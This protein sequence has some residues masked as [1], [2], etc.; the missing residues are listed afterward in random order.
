MSIDQSLI[1]AKKYEA[2]PTPLK[3]AV[4]GASPQGLDI[5]PYTALRALQHIGQA[6]Q[7]QM[8]QQAQQAPAAQ[9][10]P[11]IADAELAKAFGTGGIVAFAHG[12]TPIQHFDEGDEV[13]S[14]EEADAKVASQD[15][16]EL[17]GDPNVMNPYIERVKGI[18]PHVVDKNADDS[19]I[20]REMRRAQ[21]IMGREDPYAEF[22]NKLTSEEAGSAGELEKGKGLAMLQAAGAILEPGGL[23]RGLGKAG[24][25]FG[26]AY[27]DVLKADRAAKQARSQ[28]RFN[29]A[30][31]ERKEKLGLYRDAAASIAA[32]H[33]N[34]I[35]GQQFEVEKI[36]AEGTLAA[37]QARLAAG[38]KKGAGSSAGVQQLEAI[39][40][41]NIA[42]GMSPTKAKAA[43][44]REILGMQQ[45]KF[46]SSVSDVPVGGPKAKE[47][48]TSSAIKAGTT[49]EKHVKDQMILGD[50]MQAK[51]P[52]EQAAKKQ[53]YKDEWYAEQERLGNK[54]IK[55]SG[56]STTTEPAVALPQAAMSALKEGH[57]TT[58][59]NGQK[60]TL[61]NGKPAQVK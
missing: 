39:M 1:Y 22:R 52:E 25:A 34:A 58:F 61:Q 21:G 14:N 5:D 10:Q 47:L 20:V 4:L 35:K 36:K 55:P 31:A 12:G 29:L 9:A 40:Q 57:V 32:G 23:A 16:E 43:A 26:A 48:E 59:S 30:D 50:Y 33:A 6:K 56:A 45:Q 60:W 7:M 44:A 51:T 19:A 3:Q 17:G 2:D 46:V 28:M 53:K 49:L 27:G 18:Q 54:Q 37:A 11:S 24:Q 13:K 15:D 42:K 41:D 8:A 38:N